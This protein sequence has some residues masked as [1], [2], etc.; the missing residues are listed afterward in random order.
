MIEEELEHLSKDLSKDASRALDPMHLECNT[1]SS[2]KK[3]VATQY[4]FWRCRKN[5]LMTLLI[6]A[7]I[8]VIFDDYQHRNAVEVFVDN[9]YE[10][11]LL[12]EDISA[13][14]ESSPTKSEASSSSL[15]Y[16][17]ITKSGSPVNNL[18]KNTPTFSILPR[19]IYSVIGLEDSGTQ[20]VSR[21]ITRA[22]KK[23]KY[24]EGSR[25]TNEKSEG[26][27]IMVQHF[28]LPWGSTCQ[29]NPNPPVID[30]VIPS[31]CM[32]KHIGHK[33]MKQC[34][35]ITNDL[36]G[37]ATERSAKI[38]YPPRYQLDI[39]SHKE[40]YDAQ[41]VEQYFIIVVRD[42]KISSVARSKHCNNE[43]LRDDEEK[44]GT[45]IIINAIN[46]YILA[47]GEEEVTG[48]TYGFWAAENFQHDD[49]GKGS[50]NRKLSAL[51][52]GNNV[53]LVSYETMM[54]LGPIYVQ[55]LYEVLGIETDYVPEIR[56]GNAKYVNDNPQ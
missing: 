26:A 29:H 39:V 27:D 10:P 43:T 33:E 5:L 41:G 19:R 51:P 25:P 32:R 1:N 3:T 40:W 15:V 9:D 31:Q 56:D 6:A 35:E 50:R 34:N 13:S 38:V 7:L 54:K 16:H 2:E 8:L 36:W 42:E 45:D 28:S 37:F 11:L 22:L 46:K 12:D 53:V 47:D 48:D 23:S 17:N 20:F 30:V 55:M 4:S 44:V 21:I 18:N 52:F 14:T 24:R 49:D